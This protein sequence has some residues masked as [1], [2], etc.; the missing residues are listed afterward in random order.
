MLQDEKNTQEERVAEDIG[1]MVTKM[2]Q[3]QVGYEGRAPGWPA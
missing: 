3:A 2:T 1:R